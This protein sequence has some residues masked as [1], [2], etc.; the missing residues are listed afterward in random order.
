MREN[1]KLIRIVGLIVTLV[2]LAVIVFGFIAVRNSRSRA[3]TP[4]EFVE[5]YS[6]A[7][8]RKSAGDVLKLTADPR[9]HL[10]E[11]IPDELKKAILKYNAEKDREELK[12]QFKE[13]DMFYRAWCMTSF[14]EER[15]HGDHIHVT[16][17]VQGAKADIILVSEEGYLK[18]HPFPGIFDYEGAD[19]SKQPRQQEQRTE[20]PEQENEDAGSSEQ[21]DE[22][23]FADSESQGGETE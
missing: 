7:F 9:N 8:K 11:G 2:L 6:D 12:K 1:D 14:Y 15:P 18:I 5:K 4:R 19:N 23:S 21:Q 17:D 10:I 20:T 13:E 22:E 16:V 3:K